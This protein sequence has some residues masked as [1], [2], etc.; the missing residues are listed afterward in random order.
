[1]ETAKRRANRIHQEIGTLRAVVGGK[2]TVQTED[3]EFAARRAASCLIAPRPGDTVVVAVPDE[4][5]LWVLAIL[6][7]EDPDT[8]PVIHADG[9]LGLVVRGTLEMTGG[10]G[11]VMQSP[12]KVDIGSR[13]LSVTTVDG[14]IKSDRFRF[15]GRMVQA[16]ASTVKSFLGTMDT[17]LERFT[18]T[19]KR[20]YRF[21]EEL[22][23]TRA[24]EIDMRSKETMTLR[25]KNAFVAAKDLVKVD[26][27]QIH[28]G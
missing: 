1:M 10:A 13:E 18:Q 5:P 3:G 2:L 17:A 6:E 20:S 28:L 7:R 23:V 25:A 24:A 9:D 26:G 21:V 15:F 16:Q 22:D 14:E 12:S 11:V 27:E 19:V 4:G 8:R